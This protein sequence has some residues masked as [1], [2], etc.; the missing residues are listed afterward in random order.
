MS[1]KGSNP[2][3]AVSYRFL[4]SIYAV[5]P[6]MA[7]AIV[8][9]RFLL[10]QRGFAA[11][12]HNPYDWRWITVVF[13]YPHIIASTF[14]LFNKR[15]YDAYAP[16]IVVSVVVSLALVILLPLMGN[17]NLE[18]LVF[19][20]FTVYHVMTQQI[21]VA[22]LMW[23]KP[24]VLFR[25][26]KSILIG[27][28]ILLYLQ[29][30]DDAGIVLAFFAGYL[31]WVHYGLMFALFMLTA[32][33]ADQS[34]QRMGRYYMW[35]NCFMLMFVLACLHYGY[36]FFAVLGPR[37]V[38]DATAFNFYIAHANGSIGKTEKNWLYHAVPSRWPMFVAVPL[39]A[40]IAANVLLV[41]KANWSVVG[42]G[43]IALSFFHYCIESFI[44]KNGSPHRDCLELP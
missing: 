7:V 40:I 14:G 30:Y 9:D 18:F 17:L 23:G 12:P 19:A 10:E 28:S 21:G 15:S 39:M 2:G 37:I 11:F 33:L 6:L 27:E 34:K 16:K 3:A 22:T 4:L 35:A 41:T 8:I 24:T 32:R 42:E 13:V 44:W 38:H 36:V 20:V 43:L 5:L 25:L 29:I 1:D 26:W 31:E